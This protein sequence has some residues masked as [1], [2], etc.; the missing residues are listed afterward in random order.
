MEYTKPFLI[1]LILVLVLTFSIFSMF[2]DVSL[3]YLLGMVLVIAGVSFVG[4]LFLLPKMNQIVAVL[5]D[6]VTYYAL[7]ALF[8]SFFIDDALSLMIT[9]FIAAYFGSVAEAI[10]HIYVM[11]E[12]HEVD[13]DRPLPTRFQT[14]VSEELNDQ[15]L[16]KREEKHEKDE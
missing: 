2:N 11:D 15:V 13:R 5:L 7:F 4:D 9:T 6:F 14:E 16:M 1:K 12:L 3:L 10:Y 8:G